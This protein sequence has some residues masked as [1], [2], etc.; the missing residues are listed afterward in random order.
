M[1]IL[2]H[3]A[4]SLG[5]VATIPFMAHAAPVEITW[6]QLEEG[7]LRHDYPMQVLELALNKAGV[8]YTLAPRPVI[9]SQVRMTRMMETEGAWT[10]GFF[11]ANP[12]FEERLR[13]IRFPLFRGLLGARIG[14]THTDNLDRFAGVSTAEELMALSICQGIGWTD[15]EILSEAG[16]NV[17]PGEYDDLFKVTHSKRCDMYTRAVFEPFA[18]VNSRADTLPNLVV[19]PSLLIRYRFPYFM[20]IDPSNEELAV[21]IEEGLAIAMEDGSFQE[22]FL[23]TP[24]VVEAQTLVNEGDRVCVN[25]ENPFLTPETQALGDE[26]WQGFSFASDGS[27]AGGCRLLQ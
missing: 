24:T 1:K 25:V 14:I 11:G 9:A 19:D 3:F 10:V 13:P 20:Y 15:T 4:L 8:E 12:D 21:A 5:L 16:F 27:N 7:D 6:P 23:S 26:Y 2:K 18:E 22:L 17:V